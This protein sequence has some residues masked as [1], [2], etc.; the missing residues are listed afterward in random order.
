MSN[1][2]TEE[3][4]IPFIIV[5]GHIRHFFPLIFIGFLCLAPTEKKETIWAPFEGSNVQS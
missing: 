4:C 3:I 2:M 5:W 1:S